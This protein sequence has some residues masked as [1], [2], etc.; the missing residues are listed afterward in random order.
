MSRRRMDAVVVSRPGDEH[1]DV[2]CSSLEQHGASVWRIS[3]NT[4]HSGTLSWRP[5][6]DP[7]RF[8]TLDI[9]PR[10]PG[11]FR[12]P[13]W[14]DVDSPDPPERQALAEEAEEILFGLLDALDLRWLDAPVTV[15]RAERKLAQLTWRFAQEFRSPRRS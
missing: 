1:G 6:R 11:F 2:V 7:L 9:F 12:R 13:G 3:A 5:D 8:D 14:G 15:W 10:T 4:I